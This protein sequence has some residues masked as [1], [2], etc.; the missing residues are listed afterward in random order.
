MPS[1]RLKSNE[2]NKQIKRTHQQQSL[3]YK[4]HVIRV[5]L[6]L[7]TSASVHAEM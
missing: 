2:V 5:P 4:L 7:G 6:N 1:R 3:H